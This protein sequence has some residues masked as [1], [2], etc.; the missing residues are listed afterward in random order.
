MRLSICV[1]DCPNSC[2]PLNS[3]VSSSLERS[4]TSVSLSP[5]QHPQSLPLPFS[6]SSPVSNAR[7]SMRALVSL[8]KLVILRLCLAFD[9]GTHGIMLVLPHASISVQ[10]CS[11]VPSTWPPLTCCQHLP[12]HTKCHFF[13]SS[14]WH[15]IKTSRGRWH[16]S[17]GLL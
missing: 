6:F 14:I 13:V 8:M 12:V 4:E 15:R 7:A 10:R 5:C 11:L 2:I 3:T 16:I 17:Q 9:L 1:L